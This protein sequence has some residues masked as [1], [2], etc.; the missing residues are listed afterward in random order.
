MTQK[1]RLQ[2]RCF[3]MNIAK[4]LRTLILNN[5]CKR[6][7]LG[8]ANRIYSA[9]KCLETTKYM[10]K[11]L[12]NNVFYYFIILQLALILVSCVSI[13]ARWQFYQI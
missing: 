1:K 2:N 13:I 4:F 10:T 8:V 3:P 7:L 9:V 6:L 11:N 12:K 5:I